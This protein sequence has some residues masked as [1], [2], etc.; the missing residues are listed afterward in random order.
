MQPEN[1]LDICPIK[2]I[3]V[4]KDY[5][6]VEIHGKKIRVCCTECEA[7]IKNISEYLDLQYHKPTPPPAPVAPT[8]PSPYAIL[9]RGMAPGGNALI[10]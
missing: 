7:K 3:P 6:E 4:G 5:V 10:Y 2:G 9:S 8:N 1:F